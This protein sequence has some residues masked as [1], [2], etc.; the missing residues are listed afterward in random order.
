MPAHM[1]GN[2]THVRAMKIISNNLL[3]IA[4]MYLLQLSIRENI[5]HACI[6][7]VHDGNSL[8]CWNLVR[9]ENHI[10]SGFCHFEGAFSETFLIQKF[11]FLIPLMASATFQDKEVAFRFPS[12]TRRTLA[13]M[14]LHDQS[15]MRLIAKRLCLQ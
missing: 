9:S 8:K 6:F 3:H 7:I 12:H 11:A 15:R 14:F 4:N 1:L 10:L 13:A 2:D 5:G